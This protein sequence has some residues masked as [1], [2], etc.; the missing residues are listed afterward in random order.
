[1]NQKAAVFATAILIGLFLLV[2]TLQGTSQAISLSTFNSP[3]SVT[4]TPI[5][6]QGVASVLFPGN[7]LTLTHLGS[8][9]A[10]WNPYNG[11]YPTNFQLVPMLVKV[12]ILPTTATVQTIAAKKGHEYWLVFNEC[13]HLGGDSC[14]QIPI[15]QAILYHDRILPLVAAGD[16]NAKLI[17]GGSSAHE[18][19]LSWMTQFVL[20]YRSQ[21]HQD[22]PRAGW[23]FHIYPEVVPAGWTS[24][25][26]CPDP[27]T[28]YGGVVTESISI[29]DYIT[30][31]NAIRHWWSLYG[32][33]ND[34]I[35]ITEMGCLDTSL[36]LCPSN[37][38]PTY[39]NDITYYLNHDG[40]WIDRYA[41]FT[42]YDYR[43]VQTTLMTSAT[44]GQLSSLGIAYSQSQVVVAPHVPGFQYLRFLP[45]V[46]N[47]N[48]S[49]MGPMRQ[50]PT[51]TS[52]LPQPSN[53][54]FNSPLPLPMP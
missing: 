21:Y 10:K 52:P 1:M 7:Q 29:T 2:G 38:D 36:T 17:I 9:A 48:Q 43:F 26:P 53:T 37:S 18:C 11:T 19:G 35:W 5:P 14:G 13:E 27:D 39:L 31:A 49:G 46:L 28:W 44:S 12:N 41:W 42:D 4:P 45:I 40:L 16:P 15:S 54:T 24:G 51:F 6:R 25:Q 33:P 47:N 34:E 8:W 30:Q 22:P 3:I 32:S 50:L 23:H 20:T